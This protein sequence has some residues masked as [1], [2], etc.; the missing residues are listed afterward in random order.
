MV[1]SV[2]MFSFSPGGRPGEVSHR[3]RE[4]KTRLDRFSELLSVAYI[5]FSLKAVLTGLISYGTKQA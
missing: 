1:T 4:M 5:P 3:V 2:R